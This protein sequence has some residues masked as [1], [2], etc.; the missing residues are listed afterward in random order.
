V[1]V[2]APEQMPKGLMR[3]FWTD[4]KDA[5]SLDGPL[6]PG[7]TDFN[8]ART[9][10]FNRNP[11]PILLEAYREYGPIFTIKLLYFNGVFMLGPEANHYITVSHAKNFVW[12]EGSF[13]D[14]IP[15]LGDG[16]LTIDGEY[17]RK[18]RKVMLPA[19]HR[20]AL[21]ASTQT[22]I[23]ETERALRGWDDG[24]IVDIYHWTR[25]LA[26][27]IAMKALF[28]IDPDDAGTDSDL[29]EDFETG[30]GFYGRDY[31]LQMLRGP[32]T[33]FDR[34]QEARHSIDRVIYAEIARRRSNG[35]QE[36]PDILTMLME[37]SDED[38]WRFSDEQVRDQLMTLLFAGHDTTTSTITFLFYELARAPHELEKLLAEQDAVL[39]GRA[40]DAAQLASGL[41]L[42]DMAL[43]ETL[44]L[45]PPAWVGPRRAV[46]AFEFD[47]RH[48]PAGA[49]VHYSSWVS[50]HLPDVFPEPEA[51]V[52]ERFTPENRA[53]LPKG[54]YVPFGGGSR[55]CI[56]MRF[57][58]LEIKAIA[59]A[60]LQ[61]CRLE[62]I[63]G[64]ELSIRQM[65]TLSPRGGLPMIV[66]PR[67]AGALAAT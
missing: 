6:P 45:Y 7:P 10:A 25:E 51:F 18:S 20:E 44:R 53:K 41:P 63:G 55:T 49:Y 61:R 52:P 8:L 33:P 30:L 46:E 31:F 65:P 29:A 13:R 14:L 60:I 66:R 17:H 21:A 59:S 22:M 39:G 67:E 50:H 12:R 56:G 4:V 2:T 15:F 9:R 37:A 57:G 47:G 19:F 64:T 58:Q 5:R 54:A 28:G 40:P 43:D 26:L 32:R 35:S 24:E 48:V 62:L 1:A 42:L 16:L 3:R 23:D 34:M 11:L 38:G 36:H 27:R